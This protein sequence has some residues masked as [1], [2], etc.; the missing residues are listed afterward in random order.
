[1]KNKKPWFPVVL[2][3]VILTALFLVFQATLEAKG[4]D[5]NV[6]IAGNAIIFL[7]TIL[8]FYI[9]YRAVISPNPN[10]TVR[11]MYGSFMIK[12]FVIILAAFVY[13]MTEKKNLNKPALFTCMGLYLL[14]TVVEITSLQRLL[15]AKKNEN[16]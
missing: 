7:A 6:L 14:Y 15:K 5:V 16:A 8:S 3:F 10:A 9:S 1:M 2:L 4:F 13:I 12:F 11:S